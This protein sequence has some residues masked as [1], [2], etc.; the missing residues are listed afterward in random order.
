MVDEIKTEGYTAD[1]IAAALLKLVIGEEVERPERK[2]RDDKPARLRDRGDRE[3]R[4][5]SS[6]EDGKK[7]PRIDR[8]KMVRLFVSLGKKDHIKPGDIVGAFTSGTQI[9]GS[10]IGSIDIYDKYS[11]VEVPENTVEYV[12]EGMNQ[13]QIKGKRVNVEVAGK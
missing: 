11:F 1:Q 7:R 6:R 3:E 13:N 9:S 5:S 4:R 10:E 12:L 2:E 8:G